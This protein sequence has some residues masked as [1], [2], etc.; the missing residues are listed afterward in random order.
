M[1]KLPKLAS[2][3]IDKAS[4]VLRS[5]SEI[6]LTENQESQYKNYPAPFNSS[7]EYFTYLYLQKRDIGWTTQINFGVANSKGS[8]RA[9]FVNETL[10]IVM[11]LDG[12]HWHT[13]ERKEASDT[14]KRAQVAGRGYRVVSWVI[15]SW[16]YLVENISR[17]Y[18]EMVYGA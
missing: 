18:R 15:P 13:G 4:A 5:A 17:L 16:D 7:W 10:R 1:L 6:K 11:F 8:T 3:R 14:L 12:Q 9:D 2:L